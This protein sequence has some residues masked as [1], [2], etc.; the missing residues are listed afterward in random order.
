MTDTLLQDYQ[1]WLVTAGTKRPSPRTVKQYSTYVR[2]FVEKVGH[3]RRVSE[4]QLQQWQEQLRLDEGLGTSAKNLRVAAVRSLFRYAEDRKLRTTNPALT[5]VRMQ[6][7]PKLKP[8]YVDRQLLNQLF[9]YIS[10]LTD[11]VGIQDRAL[12]ESLYGSGLRRSEAAMLT[13]EHFHGD[14][15]LRIT[16]KG[17]KERETIVTRPQLAAVKEWALHRFMDD[18]VRETVASFGEDGAFHY[19]RRHKAREPLFVT[20][21]GHPVPTLQDPGNW[22]WHRVRVRAEQAGVGKLRAHQLRHSFGTHLLG[23][24]QVSVLEL[25]QMLGHEDVETTAGYV[26]LEGQSFQRIRM[27]H[28]R[29]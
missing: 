2:E 11:L 19:L 25:Q 14:S 13:L 5:T 24:G 6:R 12:L 8:Q 26:G 1:R 18:T 27:M 10:N 15:V 17:G 20:V 3:P 9:D 28:P 29:A 7:P 21:E 4:D 23:S 22:V 16:G